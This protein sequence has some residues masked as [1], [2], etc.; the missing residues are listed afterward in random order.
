MTRKRRRRRR[1]RKTRRGGVNSPA[2]QSL[3]KHKKKWA[4]ENAEARM[5]IR[6]REA[7]LARRPP[8]PPPR[9]RAAPDPPPVVRRPPPLPPR[10]RRH[11]GRSSHSW[12]KRTEKGFTTPMWRPGQK[13]QP[14]RPRLGQIEQEALPIPPRRRR[15]PPPPKGQVL[16]PRTFPPLPKR[17]AG[18]KRLSESGAFERE[19]STSIHYKPKPPPS[20]SFNQAELVEKP[21]EKGVMEKLGDWWSGS[22]GRRRRKKRR[23]KKRRSKKRRRR[24]QR[25]GEKCCVADECPK[26]PPEGMIIIRK[27]EYE[28]WTKSRLGTKK[29]D[30]RL[31]RLAESKRTRQGN[32]TRKKAATGNKTRKRPPSFLGN[33][34]KKHTLKKVETGKKAHKG[35]KQAELLKSSPMFAKVRAAS[36]AQQNNNNNAEQWNPE[37]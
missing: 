26:C 12:R 36:A 20:V 9:R 17:K 19:R 29:S 3:L 18:P 31:H 22:G 33:I 16:G 13:V 34:T 14:L 7:G 1:R 32:K 5:N 25:G 35:T 6:F 4:P 23:R 15:G 37:A 28:K 10:P 2:L 8:H 21:E 24:R 27:E 11:T 30:S